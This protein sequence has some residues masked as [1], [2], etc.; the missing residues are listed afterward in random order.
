MYY[1]IRYLDYKR[2]FIKDANEEAPKK[3][4]LYKNDI[5]TT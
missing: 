2:S 5:K 1:L 4:G 3:H